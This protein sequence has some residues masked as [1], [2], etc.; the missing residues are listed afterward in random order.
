M[1]FVDFFDLHLLQTPTIFLA[2]VPEEIT[3]L[4]AKLAL[5]ISPF[6]SARVQLTWLTFPANNETFVLV[7]FTHKKALRRR[8]KI[9]CVGFWG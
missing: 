7:L 8:G 5:I 1:S 6:H 2:R 3:L 4:I 9:E